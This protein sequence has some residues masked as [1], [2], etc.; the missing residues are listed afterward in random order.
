[1]MYHHGKDIELNKKTFE[2]LT[3][4]ID[5]DAIYHNI[6]FLGVI[7]LDIT[8]MLIVFFTAFKKK[9]KDAD[10]DK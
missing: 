4:N 6:G 5:H 1:M 10:V 7:G 2:A 8:A 9:E 3:G